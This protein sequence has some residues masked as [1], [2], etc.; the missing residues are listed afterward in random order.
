M[1]T[2]AII[3][4]GNRGG[5]YA[6]HLAKNEKVK[7]VSVCDVLQ[8]SLRQAH[9]LYGVEEKALFLKEEEFFKEKRAD[10][11]IVSTLDEMHYHQTIQALSLGYDVLLE[12]PVSP[13]YE[14]CKK[15]AEYADQVGRKVIVCHNLRY[16]PFY[17][18]L[19][20]LVVAGE[21]GDVVSMEQAENVGF[22]HYMGS[23]VRG[24]WHRQAD[25]SPI[26]LQK[27][28]HD[29]DIIYWIL[30][31]KCE[32]LSS[33][34]SLAYYTEKNAPK[35]SAEH[36]IDCKI[37]CPY[38]SCDFYLKYPGA[39]WVPYGFDKSKENI[40]RYLADKENDYGKCV[41]HM[42]NDVC[43]RQTVNMQFEGGVTASLFMHGFA[44]GTHRITRVY[45][46]KGVAYGCLEDGIWTV[47]TYDGKK[48]EYDVRK[49]IKENASHSGG[50]A[51][52]VEDVV[53]YLVDGKPVLGLSLVED[54]I[55]SHKLAFAAEE[56]RISGEWIN[57]GRTL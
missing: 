56:S 36:C 49:V 17:Q 57:P 37:D 3:G 48:K 51:K 13:V 44:N 7:I 34:G 22:T 21:I 19:K 38:N 18:R 12:K 39:M 23:F 50:D 1:K 11:L 53:D 42:D 29:L 30:G 35:G 15:I 40:L 46:T 24:N 14:H 47:E 43:D 54:S 10:V 52:L 4:L 27:C 20:K 41:Y 45:G 2:I 16:T 6:K 26:I 25:T 5:V 31:K 33:S 55:Y 9:E 8:E 28:C 32:K